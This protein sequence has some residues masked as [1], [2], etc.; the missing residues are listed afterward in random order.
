MP[1][2]WAS[3]RPYAFEAVL[4]LHCLHCVNRVG[5]LVGYAT[6]PGKLSVENEDERNAPYTEALLH[7]L[8]S[9]DRS[10]TMDG[11]LLAAN[12]RVAGR[13][14]VMQVPGLFGYLRDLGPAAFF[15]SVHGLLPIDELCADDRL[16]RV[17]DVVIKLLDACLGQVRY[18]P[19]TVH[20]Y[21]RGNSTFRMGNEEGAVP[22]LYMLLVL[23]VLVF[24]C[25]IFH[26]SSVC[27]YLG[28]WVTVPVKSR[29]TSHRWWSRSCPLA[30]PPQS[31]WRS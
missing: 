11:V 9:R 12:A 8:G 22:A 18:I 16:I 7:A 2:A 1:F 23:T 6:S 27:I 3:R 5:Y 24:F 25:A 13:P 19:V 15:C 4:C 31:L 29:T 20:A 17:Q 30:S 28:R 10:C 26:V 14:D 21:R